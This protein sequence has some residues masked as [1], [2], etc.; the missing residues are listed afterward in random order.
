MIH[1]AHV[2]SIQTFYNTVTFVKD[3]LK[4]SHNGVSRTVSNE[5]A[6]QAAHL[7]YPTGVTVTLSTRGVSVANAETK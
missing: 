5:G 4:M 2:D 3:T 1:M 6:Q 7:T